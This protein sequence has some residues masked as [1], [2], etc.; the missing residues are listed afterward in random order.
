[1]LGDERE[2][3]GKGE[4][5]GTREGEEKIGTDEQMSGGERGRM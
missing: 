5:E 4:A 1:M 2:R 3:K